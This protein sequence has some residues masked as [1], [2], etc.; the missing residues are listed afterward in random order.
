M[1]NTGLTILA[2]PP[3]ASRNESER[4]EL[5]AV[6]RILDA[7][8]AE[9][10]P[11]GGIDAERSL[12]QAPGRGSSFMRSQNSQ[13]QSPSARQESSRAGGTDMRLLRGS[14]ESLA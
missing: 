5:Q 14:A 6:E 1:P 2:D 11:D 10:S 13:V 3:L 9:A 8:V 12:W 7:F 4:S